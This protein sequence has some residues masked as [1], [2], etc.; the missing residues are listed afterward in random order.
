ADGSHSRH[1]EQPHSVVML[2]AAH[3]GPDMSNSGAVGQSAV[4]ANAGTI[5]SAHRATALARIGRIDIGPLGTGASRG[6]GAGMCD[7]S[8]Q[9]ARS[10]DA[11]RRAIARLARDPCARAHI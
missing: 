5:E 10:R 3:A 7:Y 1:S 2:P 9:R 4:V 8:K 11:R 6:A